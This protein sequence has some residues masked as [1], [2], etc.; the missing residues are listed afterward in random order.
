MRAGSGYVGENDWIS[1]TGE[2]DVRLA[3]LVGVSAVTKMG[4]KEEGA[5]GGAGG[6]RD[7]CRKS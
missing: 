1:G 2:E 5:V 3:D 7:A 6:V 4:K